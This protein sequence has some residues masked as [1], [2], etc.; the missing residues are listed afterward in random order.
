MGTPC[1]RMH[2]AKSVASRC[3]WARDGWPL[4]ADDWA[5]LGEF[6]P[7]PAISVA[8]RIDKE[9]VRG[10]DVDRNMMQWYLVSGHTSA[11]R[12]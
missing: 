6:D 10:R 3:I 11:T 12:R 7:Q 2:L 1:E 4:E 5:D 8:A 9:T